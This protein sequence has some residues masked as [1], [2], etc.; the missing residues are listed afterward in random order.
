MIP[1]IICGGF[2]TKLWPVSREHQPKHF[3]KLINGKSLFELNYEAL[4]QKFESSEIYVSTNEDQAKIAQNLVAEIPQENYIL[5]PEMRN[6]GPATGLIAATLMKKGFGD[7]PF[8]I[9]QADVLREPIGDFIKMIEACDKLAR[10][11]DKYITGGFRPDFPV[12]GVDYLVKG[13][14]V[15]DNN[16]VGIFKVDKFVWR[17]SKEQTEELIKQ[18]TSLVH[19][20]HSCMTPKNMLN[21]LQKY[22]NEWYEPLANIVNGADVKSEYEKMPP[23]P[24]EDVTQQVFDNDG[25]LICELPFKWVDFGTYESLSKYLKENNLYKSGENVVDMDGKDNFVWLD[26]PNK[27]VAMIGVDELIV[28]DTG[29]VILICRKDQSGRV[30]E[31]LNEVKNRKLALT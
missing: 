10:Q 8:M 25:A 12:M 14:R 15:S 24:I 13:E 28:V 7:I 3:L 21:M 18:E 29:D 11:E 9:I 30:K 16:E 22:K 20:N 17:S 19:A 5:E 26:D 1:V 23:G 2:G 6:Q 27:I 4:R 31:A